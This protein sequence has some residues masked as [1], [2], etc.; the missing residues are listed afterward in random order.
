M[1]KLGVGL[2]AT[3]VVVA[4]GAVWWWAEVGMELPTGQAWVFTVAV[5][6][7]AGIC[8]FYPMERS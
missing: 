6:V 5:L 3:G 1:H 7:V 4:L 8:A 2:I